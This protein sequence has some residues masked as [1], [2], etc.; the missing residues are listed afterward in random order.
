MMISIASG[1]NATVCTSH[2]PCQPKMLA[3]SPSRV[4]V[5]SPCRP[6]IR[7]YANATMK[8]GAKSGSRAT[9][10]KSRRPGMS[11]R[12]MAK[13]KIRPLAVAVSVEMTIITRLLRAACIQRMLLGMAR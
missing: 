2:S 9:A 5:I 11:G 10:L 3:S 6:N 1:K 13:A 12:V 7:M 4:L 8:G